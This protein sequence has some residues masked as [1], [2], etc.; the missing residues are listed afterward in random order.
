MPVNKNCTSAFDIYNKDPI[1]YEHKT[2]IRE[3]RAE[4]K[5]TFTGR[6]EPIC[7]IKIDDGI[8]PKNYRGKTCDYLMFREINEFHYI[9]EL[10]SSDNISRAFKQIINSIKYLNEIR[11]NRRKGVIPKEKIFGIIAGAHGIPRTDLDRLKDDFRR[12]YGQ[13][14][15]KKEFI[16]L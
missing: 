11:L 4:F 3:G 9:I 1:H 14:L 15:E 13:K 6:N 16:R 8:A 2:S 10:K 7:T 12:L 5:I